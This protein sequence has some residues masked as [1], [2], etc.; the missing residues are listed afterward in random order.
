[1]NSQLEPA[2]KWIVDILRKH[3]VPFQIA[4]GFAVHLYGG[5]RPIND[6]DIDIPDK[7]FPN[8]IPDIKKYIKFGPAQYKDEVWDLNLITLDYHGQEIDICGA[9]GA[10]IYNRTTKKL[11]P[12]PCQFETASLI[13]AYGITVPVMDAHDLL[14]YKRLRNNENQQEDIV[15]MEKYIA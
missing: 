1:M 13:S 10:K 11:Q 8:I 6:I 4:G 7:K 12:Y 14:A 9:H 5:T 15:A 3:K 2:L